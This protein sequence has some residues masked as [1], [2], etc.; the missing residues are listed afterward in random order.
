MNLSC[1]Y[2]GL[3]L[4]HPFIVGASPM[5]DDLDLVRRL[6]DAGAAAI[7]ARSLFEEQVHYDELA[8]AAAIDGPAHAFAEAATYLPEPFVRGADDYLE[9]LTGLRAAV[10]VPLFA[11]LNGVHGGR[12]LDY[13]EQLVAAGA[14]G[15]ELNLYH[16][17]TDW[18]ESGAELEARLLGMVASIRAR[19]A[20][21][22]AVKLS[23]AY[24]SLPH[25]ASAVA[26]AGADALVLFNR[27]YQAD[28]DPE[29]LEVVRR[30]DLSTSAELLLRLRWLAILS[31]QL[32]TPLAVTGG[33][34]TVI[35]AV[36]A[37]MAGA[38][39]IQLVSALLQRG[40]EHLATLRAELER[41]LEEYGYTSL[42]AMRGS[43][44]L[45]R[46]PDPSAFERV[47]YMEILRGWRG[48]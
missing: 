25:F 46:C 22:I 7:V 45:S 3:D 4:P 14:D 8:A 11:S 30:L 18:R 39:A 19:I 24:T 16:L 47:N 41:W 43:M 17:P 48:L 38:S 1:R 23:P 15:I 36:K 9:L 28:I 10:G 31:A 20:A 26:E 32:R 2:M 35:D 44:N 6:E 13:A 12:W 27:F 37:V 33:V 5:V 29:T 34:H 42:D 21:P 40:P